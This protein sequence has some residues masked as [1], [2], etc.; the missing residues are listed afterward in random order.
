[1][2]LGDQVLDHR[3][4]DHGADSTRRARL[5]GRA[6]RAEGVR[7]PSWYQR[8]V[9]SVISAMGRPDW[10]A[11]ALILSSTSVKLRTVGD[12]VLAVDVA[13]EAEEDVEDHHG[14]R[15]AEVG[16]VVD[17]GPQTY[18]RTLSGSREP[19]LS[20]RRVGCWVRRIVVMA[21][22]TGVGPR[23]LV[24]LTEGVTMR[25]RVTGVSGECRQQMRMA[26]TVIAGVLAGPCPVCPLGRAGTGG[27]AAH[28]RRGMSARDGD[29]TC[30]ELPGT[31]KVPEGARDLWTAAGRRVRARGR[32]MVSR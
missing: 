11:R 31:E 27:A 8:I 30:A 16:A 13:E 18:I 24:D 22:R 10:A 2:A 1:V 9:S 14:P 4:R 19:E 20:L 12:V 32:R 26:R 25:A 6:E 28:V 3:G 21:P 15:V 17:G 29:L 23:A 7:V 5:L